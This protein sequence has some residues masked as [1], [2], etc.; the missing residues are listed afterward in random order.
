LFS[1]GS[2]D[3]RHLIWETAFADIK[4]ITTQNLARY[5][6]EFAAGISDAC[7]QICNLLFEEPISL[8]F[9]R[10]IH[11]RSIIGCDCLF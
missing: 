5:V 8:P 4:W 10:D 3:P 2:A 1:Y 9:I 11:G 7:F 6:S